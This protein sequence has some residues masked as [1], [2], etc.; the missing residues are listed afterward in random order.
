MI[1]YSLKNIPDNHT[2]WISRDGNNSGFK[3]R[4]I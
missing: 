3:V 1:E 4:D 2:I